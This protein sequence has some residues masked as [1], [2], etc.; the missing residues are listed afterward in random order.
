MQIEGDG[1]TLRLCEW[2]YDLKPEDI[3]QDVLDRAKHLILDGIGC[4]LVGARVPW[5]E[6]LEQ[7]L[8]YCEPEGDCS[9]I[10]YSKVRLA[11]EGAF[12]ET[13]ADL[14]HQHYGPLAAAML[15]GS[16]IQATELD[17]FHSGAPIHSAS[18]LVPTLLAASEIR[19]FSAGTPAP[20]ISGLN[21]LV[22]AI[23]GFEIGPRVGLAL[24]GADVFAQGWH[25]GPVFGPAAAGAAASK[26]FGLDPD[27]MESAVGIACTQACGLISSQYEGMIKRAQHAFA[28]RSGLFAALVART[29]YLGIKKVLERPFGGLLATISQGTTKKPRYMVDE[30]TKGLGKR[31][32]TSNIRIK[33]HA[34]VGG[35]HGQVEVIAKLQQA[36]LDRFAK[37]NLHKIRKMTVYLSEPVMHHDG[38]APDARPLATT[39]AQLN[40]AYVGA[41]Q[42]ID[43]QVLLAQFGDAALDR[44]EVWA[45]IPKITCEHDAHFDTPGFLCGAR[46]RV[47]F[48]DGTVVEEA[49]DAPKGHNPPIENEEIVEKYRRLAASVV[50]E[51]R[52]R[53]IEEMVLGLEKVEDMRRLAELLAQ[54]VRNPL[55]A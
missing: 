11:D 46:V 49:Q 32:E 1:T 43:G 25:S 42:L 15:N 47:E 7:S 22:A 44:D 26:L 39:G 24:H 31:W 16:F 3:P 45:L 23:T 27:S 37:E 50:D 14:M 54:P 40:A 29:G 52:A 41:S 6:Q 35:C 20:P 13:T 33:L 17:D 34:C 51:E 53:K 2:V 48:D 38:W 55:A 19:Q 12:S 36:H 21:F 9:V 4:G 10:G 18:V 8:H 30:V 5:S 28:A